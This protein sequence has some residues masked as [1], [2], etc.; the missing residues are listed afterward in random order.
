[1]T[2]RSALARVGKL[3]AAELADGRPG[4]ATQKAM[5][6]IGATPEL[7]GDLAELLM[8][9]G[10]KKR[11]N[12]DTISAYSHLLG[13]ALEQLRYAVDR[14]SP[15]AMGFVERLRSHLF[16]T[17]IS[18]R[19]SPPILLLILHQ[20]ASAKLE[21]GNELRLVMQSMVEA[22][23]E[24]RDKV[25]PGAWGDHLAEMVEEFDGD[26][27]AIHAC[28]EETAT[29]LPEDMRC[30]FVLTTLA[31]PDPVLREAVLGFLCSPWS[32]VRFKIAETLA[33]AAPHEVVSP[34]MHRRS[35]AIRDWL[36]AE[37]RSALDRVI[38]ACRANDV[39]RADWPAVKQARVLATGIDG[40]GA[41]S[42][43]I[44]VP[45]GRKHTIASALGKVGAGV[46]D[47]WVKRG[48]TN[49]EMRDIERRFSTEAFLAPTTSDYGTTMLKSFLAM[50][51]A[52]GTMPPFGLLAVAEAAGLDGLA[53]ETMPVERLVEMLAGAMASQH[54]SATGIDTALAAS[55]HWP[56]MHPM[57]ESW[58]EDN[59]EVR[60]LLAKRKP[61]TD[62][63]V[64]LLN[65]P[66]QAHRRR[67]AELLAWTALGLK[68]RP[69]GA[70]WQDL[71]VVAREILSDRPLGEIPL[72]Q[73]IAAT[74]V[75]V[76]RMP[77]S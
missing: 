28:L 5:E 50:N 71:A 4:D 2:T 45:E 19:V 25:A 35:I 48:V 72:M 38:E 24:S 77:R 52:A 37:Q 57:I 26:E 29:A 53:P 40:S 75:A 16:E 6:T 21:M 23:S 47:A 31:E 43:M 76:H 62:P 61:K 69:E 9:E 36:P 65:G 30:D 11:P 13:H 44:I 10:A 63:R 22:D 20:F 49:A 8:K 66:L 33:Q 1:M 14:E 34:V 18:A 74:T 64:M 51:V 56:K 15:D 27:F 58:F 3:V 12:D 70:A 42:I 55:A 32:D 60:A 46:R 59:A 17:A 41:H 54:L 73:S 68:S 67:W 7:A 39:A